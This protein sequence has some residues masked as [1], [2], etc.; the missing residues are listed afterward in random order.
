MEKEGIQANTITYNVVLKACAKA[1]RGGD[2]Q[3]TLRNPGPRGPREEKKMSL[4]YSKETKEAKTDMVPSIPRCT[5][6]SQAF[7]ASASPRRGVVC[8]IAGVLC[9]AWRAESGLAGTRR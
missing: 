2:A 7:I 4:D 6:R 9:G 8:W 5:L 3:R 1:A